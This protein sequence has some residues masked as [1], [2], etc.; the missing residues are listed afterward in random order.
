MPERDPDEGDELK[1]VLDHQSLGRRL[2]DFGFDAAARAALAALPQRVPGLAEQVLEAL[3]GLPWPREAAL[4]GPA[5]RFNRL[6]ARFAEWDGGGIWFGDLVGAWVD[7]AAA[8]M[9]HGWPAL[10]AERT[11]EATVDALGRG[12]GDEAL[13]H[14]GAAIAAAGKLLFFLTAVLGEAAAAYGESLRAQAEALDLRTGLPNGSQARLDLDD[15]MG[16]RTPEH[17]VGVVVLRLEVGPAL[18]RM[19]PALA[20]RLSRQVVSRLRRALRPQDRLYAGEEWEFIVLLPALSSS[21][22]ITLAAT[23]LLSLFEVPFPVLGREYRLAA[24]AGGAVHPENGD[25][26]AGLLQSARLALHEARRGGKRFEPFHA[27]MDHSAERY[28]A[29]ERTFLVALRADKLELHLQPQVDL[30]GGRC[31][32]AEALLRWPADAGEAVAPQAIIEIAE[33]AGV[34]AQFSR[35]L[36]TRAARILADFERSG[37]AV[38]LSIN[39]TANDL[40]DA[41]LP[42]MIEQILATWRVAP[43]RLTLELTES[44]MVSDE[45]HARGILQRLRRLGCRLAVDDF[46]TGYSSMAYLRQLP[47]QELKIDQLFVRRMSETVQD[48]EI[49]HSM[50]RL[51]HSL[52][53][54]VVAEGVETEEALAL[55][56]EFGCERVQGYLLGRPMPLGEF[57]TWCGTRPGG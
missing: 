43:Q 30:A 42:D 13:T 55:L 16:R 47:L 1:L 32:G 33:E 20:E 54:D 14:H 52:R 23:R 48:R 9:E 8:G 12:A 41:E 56:K 6:L 31:T 57:M 38:Q 28:A 34:G 2:A 5:A 4:A 11:F 10:C 18:L 51:A 25:D 53:L 46:G 45:E 40:R 17:H 50:V 27:E 19:P 29:L 15:A 26:A 21:A 39:L 36:V 24:V 7:L 44:A 35:W 37:L 49:V 22:H 3:E